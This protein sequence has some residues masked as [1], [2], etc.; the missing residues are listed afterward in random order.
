MSLLKIILVIF[1]VY[2]V[3]RF[4][5]MYQVMKKISEQQEMDSRSRAEKDDSGKRSQDAIKADFKI[6]D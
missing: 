5:Q 1:A 4:F 2:F 6:I 3:R